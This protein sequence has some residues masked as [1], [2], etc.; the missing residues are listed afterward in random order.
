MADP[1]CVLTL[2][3]MHNLFERCLSKQ[4]PVDRLG[5][6]ERERLRRGWYT[7]AGALISVLLAVRG[8]GE[9]LQVPESVRT[10]VL[11]AWDA[12]IVERGVATIMAGEAK[13]R[14]GGEGPPQP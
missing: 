10:A 8:D 9:T 11:E 13:G 4:C 3:E 2:A 6:D 7:G 5:P 1:P 14:P 12:E